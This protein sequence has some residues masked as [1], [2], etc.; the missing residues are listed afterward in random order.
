MFWSKR[1]HTFRVKYI[2]KRKG[3]YVVLW[4]IW[5][6]VYLKNKSDIVNSRRV[7]D[8]FHQVIMHPKLSRL[9]R[10][11]GHVTIGEIFYLGWLKQP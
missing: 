11:N 2:Y 8:N 9:E 1:R 5:G 6:T 4:D 10:C 7:K 3:D